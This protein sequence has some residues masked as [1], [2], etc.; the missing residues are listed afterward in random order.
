MFLKFG[1]IILLNNEHIIYFF[2]FIVTH[3]NNELRVLCLGHLALQR[4]VI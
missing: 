4:F 2:L 1:S 3:L